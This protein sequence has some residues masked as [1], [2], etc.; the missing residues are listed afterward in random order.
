LLLTKQKITYIVINNKK[1]EIESKL[2]LGGSMKK[3]FTIIVL[4]FS[5]ALFAEKTRIFINEIEGMNMNSKTK[6]V[7]MEL[8][9]MEFNSYDYETVEEESLL[10][11]YSLD[12]QIIRFE[13]SR[14]YFVATLYK[15]T[16]KEHYIK[17]IINDSDKLDIFIARVVKA[18]VKMESIDD[19][20]DVTNLLSEEETIS[21]SKQKMKIKFEGD[22]GIHFGTIELNTD[23]NYNYLPAYIG[24]GYGF[25][26]PDFFFIVKS[27]SIVQGLGIRIGLYKITNRKS[28]SFFYGANIGAGVL[29]GPYSYYNDHFNQ[30]VDD[31]NPYVAPVVAASVGGIF[32][33]TMKINLKPE[34][35]LEFNF[36]E[37]TKMEVVAALSG[38]VTLIY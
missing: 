2:K 37:S 19:T 13:K 21:E 7:I 14:A 27:Y 38:F 31:M 20:K 3:F 26:H 5:I 16:E 34:L 10:H 25:Y 30:L 36:R 28:N 6:P 18:I 17:K 29:W 4:L 32:F 12:V 24:I 23:R 15:G 33:R 8:L 1:I 9:K 11:D 22:V 35:I